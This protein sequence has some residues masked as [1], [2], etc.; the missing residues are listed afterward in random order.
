MNGRVPIVDPNP[1]VI[2]DT[3]I[4]ISPFCCV[5]SPLEK[6]AGINFRKP[7]VILMSDII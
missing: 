4:I 3:S 7:R 1:S 6:V 5:V 2:S